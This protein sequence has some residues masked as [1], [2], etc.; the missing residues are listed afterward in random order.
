MEICIWLSCKQ[1]YWPSK[2]L[3]CSTWITSECEQHWIV[4]PLLDTLSSWW[5]INP[6]KKVLNPKRIKQNLPF[7][8]F[9]TWSSWRQLGYLPRPPWCVIPWHTPKKNTFTLYGTPRKP[10]GFSGKKRRFLC[11]ILMF[12]FHVNFRD[13]YRWALYP[14]KKIRRHALLKAQRQQTR[15]E[16]H[17]WVQQALLLVFLSTYPHENRDDVFLEILCH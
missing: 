15:V 16:R 9:F 13:R 12:S 3:G 6:Q 5:G 11:K 8:H 1:N 2:A 7:L 14:L 4:I 17:G 10:T